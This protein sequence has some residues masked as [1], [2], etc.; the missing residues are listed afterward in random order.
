MRRGRLVAG[1]Q[2]SVEERRAETQTDYCLL[3]T[4]NG[5]L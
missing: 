1:S 3:T 4:A 5:K 2:Q